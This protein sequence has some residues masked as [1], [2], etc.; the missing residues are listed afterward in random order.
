MTVGVTVGWLTQGVVLVSHD[1]GKGVRD[2]AALDDL[3]RLVC[4]VGKL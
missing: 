1:V 3:L 4:I 2:V